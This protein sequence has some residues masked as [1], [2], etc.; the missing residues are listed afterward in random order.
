MD[1][2][3]S[4]H[5]DETGD[6]PKLP[7]RVCL[8]NTH[9]R[10]RVEQSK[11]NATSTR[12][13]RSCRSTLEERNMARHPKKG[14]LTRSA[15]GFLDE[16]G[17]A[18]RPIVRYTWARRGRTP[19]IKSAGGWKRR[20]A[21]GT[22]LRS[23]YGRHLRFVFALQKRAVRGPDCIRYL[24][25]IK[26][27][28]NGKRLIILWDGLPAHRAKI[29]QLWIHHNRSWLSVERF[30]AYD[31]DHNPAEYVWSACKGKNMA[32][33]LPKNMAALDRKIRRSFKRINASETILRGC[34]RASELY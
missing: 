18:D 14:A 27:L 8:E 12:E 22:L 34:L 30:P 24:E 3:E 20:T 4:T 31:P 16:S 23:P 28:M 29:V 13:K 9:A 11:A 7:H 10:P 26:R 15:L 32:H 19:Y 21:I 25:K 1:T 5:R 33:Y 17:F 6:A 2:R